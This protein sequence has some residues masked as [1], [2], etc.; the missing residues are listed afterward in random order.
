MGSRDLRSKSAPARHPGY[1]SH[2]PLK[3]YPERTPLQEEI[4]H[5]EKADWIQANRI[6][7][8]RRTPRRIQAHRIQNRVNE[9]SASARGRGRDRR[10]QLGFGRAGPG[11]IASGRHARAQG[12]RNR[13]LPF[14]GLGT[15]SPDSHLRPAASD[16]LGADAGCSTCAG[17][18]GC[19]RRGDARARTEDRAGDTADPQLHARGIFGTAPDATPTDARPGAVAD[20]PA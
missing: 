14:C 10:G 19:G 11:R 5:G 1:T 17:R 7:K 16:R 13:D 8:G 4:R 6:E 2:R 3:S 9:P 18:M 20:A 15:H 12:A